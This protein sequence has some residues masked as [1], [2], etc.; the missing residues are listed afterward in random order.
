M[1]PLRQ[2]EYQDPARHVEFSHAE[3]MR[4][5]HGCAVCEFR[6]KQWGKKCSKAKTPIKGKPFCHEF[7]LEQ[8]N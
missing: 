2:F 1:K 3:D 5:K 4:D 6:P 7:Q 8:G